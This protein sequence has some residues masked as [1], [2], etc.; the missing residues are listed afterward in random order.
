MVTQGVKDGLVEQDARNA[1]RHDELLV[2][3]SSWERRQRRDVF[4]ALDQEASRSSAE[5][6]R[7]AMPEVSLHSHPHDTLRAALRDA[8]AFGLW[9]EFGVA[10]GTTLRIISEQRSAAG[11]F[12][13]DS[14]EGLP[15]RWRLGFDEG[16]FRTDQVP[17]IPGAQLVVGSF[18][19]VLPTFLEKNPG[20]VTFAHLD[21]D[22]YSSTVTAL[23][24]LASRFQ[25]GTILL[26]DEFYNYPGWQ[27]NEYRAWSEHVER[28]G[29]EF[30]YVHLTM[31]DEQVAVRIT[32]LTPP[33]PELGR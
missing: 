25:V 2:W 4:T 5:L 31:D 23:G 30:E 27:K 32:S 33:E 11:V 6:V 3:L 29:I 13:F 22:L 17:E 16:M 10:S 26:F 8:P 18:A 28:T 15:E 21:A 9:L 19:D 1:S 7:V 24:A 20:P 12:G 14:F